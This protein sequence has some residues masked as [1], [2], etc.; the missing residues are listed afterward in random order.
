[1][2]NLAQ[3]LIL[4]QQRHKQ[5]L[6]LVHEASTTSD[7]VLAS[8]HY[9]LTTRVLYFSTILSTSTPLHLPDF[10]YW[11]VSCSS[12][13]TEEVN[14]YCVPRW[15]FSVSL[16][17]YQLQMLCKHICLRQI[18]PIP[19][20]DVNSNSAD[21]L[22]RTLWVR[23][24]CFM[25][26]L[27]CN[28]RQK[29]FSRSDLERVPHKVDTTCAETTDDGAE[30]PSQHTV[31]SWTANIKNTC[32]FLSAGASKLFT[33]CEEFLRSCQVKHHSFRTEWYI[34]SCSFLSVLWCQ[35]FRIINFIE[36]TRTNTLF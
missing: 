11:W 15:S 34:C 26:S 8:A 21:V 6:T 12:P 27:H 23:A 1:M 2:L 22:Q 25:I 7:F 30:K 35:S 29:P 4:M 24:V 17:K 14:P 13:F 5:L 32:S 16:S 18:Q 9:Q 19:T 3:K 33:L 20:S 31:F 28:F 10:D 36:N